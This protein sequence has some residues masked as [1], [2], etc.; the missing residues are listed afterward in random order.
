MIRGPAGESAPAG[1]PTVPL[2]VGGP[3]SPAGATRGRGQPR[4]QSPAGYGPRPRRVR[5]IL[6]RTVVLLIAL[7]LLALVAFGALLAVTPSVGNARQL[8]KAQATAHQAVYPGPPVPARF[9][10]SLVATEDHRF[11]S[12][13]GIDVFA[14]GR[15][16][17][18]YLTGGG[19]QGGATL[20][21]QLAK[22]LYTQ[23][24][25]G[26]KVE[27]EQVALAIKLDMTYTK[28]QILRMY[29]GVVYF[30]NGYY[31][32]AA[33]SCGYFGVRPAGLSWPEAAL[34]AGLVQGPTADDPVTHPAT[35]RAREAHVLGRLVATGVL[36]P[37]QAA[38][39][40]AVPLAT[41]LA[42]SGSSCTG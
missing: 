18:G 17:A 31:G 34:L 5:R 38:A 1:D 35:A 15:V 37:A 42:H 8:A 30:G 4:Y 20:Y 14:I 28:K 24:R 13:P 7:M 10:A 12:E 39:A 25:S 19:D 16:A 36:T 22:V 27:A 32:L 40:Q 6:R 41:M 21:Q 33:A 26:L 29:A 11:Y 3:V 9:A 2:P 23:G